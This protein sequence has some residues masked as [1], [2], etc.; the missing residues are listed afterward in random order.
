MSNDR[1]KVAGYSRKTSYQGGIEYRN[2]S[3]DLVGFQLASNGNTPLFTIG[4][5]AV[6][7]NLEPKK[8]KIMKLTFKN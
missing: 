7:T 3:P 4:N 6:T 8:N 2:F 5:F 1:I